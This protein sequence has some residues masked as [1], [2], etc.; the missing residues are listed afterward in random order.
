MQGLVYIF[1][2]LGGLGIAAAA[3]FGFTFSPIEAFV[4]GAVFVCLAVVTLERALRRR[5][6]NRLEKAIDDIARLLSTDAQAGA[7]LGQ[8]LNALVDINAGKRL[9]A[10]E[11]DISVLGTVTRQVAEAVA[12][13]EQ[14]REAEARK[15]RPYAIDPVEHPN[16]APPP[17]AL[18]APIIPL[19]MLRQAMDEHRLIFHIEPIIT[20]PQRRPHGYD[21]VPRLM[22]EDG[23]L[24][25]APDFM[26]QQ[27]G[28][29]VTRRI[30]RI[31]I[32]EAITIA[33]RAATGGQP[34][35]IYV[36]LTRATLID[37][38]AIDKIV[39]MLDANRVITNRIAICVA[40]TEWDTMPT[41]QRAALAAFVG[42]GVGLSLTEARSLRL[43]FSEL[44]SDGVRSVRV[45][46]P[47]FIE[48]PARYTD[49]HTSDVAAYLK[50][51][52]VDLIATGVASEQ[53][54][55]SVLEDGL[56]LAQGPHIAGPGPVRPDLLVE[57]DPVAPIPHRAPA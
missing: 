33:R 20:L 2:A 47:R 39:V 56:T 31:A 54:L 18:P 19:E 36:P 40:E 45:D 1:I 3:Y 28:E 10:V 37:A 24:A 17:P 7:V 30:E 29:P 8:R 12:E 53:Q 26:P 22:L 4:V 46:A 21:L 6:E 42:K 49:F 23:E 51:F 34:I 25:D 50:R 41:S 9:E 48:F 27:G 55:L 15:A 14:A 43:D 16:A 44:S 13:L 11:A 38:I 52:D 57:R 5:A 32:E 35:T